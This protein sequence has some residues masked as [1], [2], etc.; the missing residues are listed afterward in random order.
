MSSKR[1]IKVNLK[2]D[3][4]SWP[5]LSVF[6]GH[7]IPALSHSVNIRKKIAERARACAD[8]PLFF[9]YNEKDNCEAFANL[10]TGVVTMEDVKKTAQEETALCFF[11]CAFACL[12]SCK[13][14]RSLA[15]VAAERLQEKGLMEK[16]TN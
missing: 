15:K 4:Y 8:P 13:R 12:N 1:T 5:A 2:F 9:D 11:C 10:M 16:T 7:K 6:L 3:L 14:R